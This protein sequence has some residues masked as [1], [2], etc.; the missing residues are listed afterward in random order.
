MREALAI[1]RELL[2]AD[3][4][5]ARRR[6]QQSR[7]HPVEEREPAGGRGDVPRGAEYRPATAR[8]RPSGDPDQAAQPRGA[9]IAIAAGPEEA[10]PLAGKPLAI[11]RKI[12]GDQ[13]P[14][15]SR[16]ASTSLAALLEDRGRNAEAEALLREALAIAR[17]RRTAR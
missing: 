15:I 4:P 2:P 9:A 3:D 17:A 14:D 10:E 13:H 7:V 16:C 8:Q 5:T 12:F 1:K 6:P 11:R